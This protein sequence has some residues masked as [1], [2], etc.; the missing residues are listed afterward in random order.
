MKSRHA[1]LWVRVL[2]A[3]QSLPLPFPACSAVASHPLFS[4]KGW[5][6]TRSARDALLLLKAFLEVGWGR[7]IAGS[8]LRLRLAG[9]QA[10]VQAY[11]LLAEP[12]CE[13]LVHTL[14][15]RGMSQTRSAALW[16]GCQL[17]VVPGLPR[18]TAEECARGL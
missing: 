3:P 18:F 10:A 5:D 8:G 1:H 13:T 9:V 12:T 17:F 6:P 16:R 11:L 14:G 2:T 4:I 15:H 7:I